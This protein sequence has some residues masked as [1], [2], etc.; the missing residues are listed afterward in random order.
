MRL[1]LMQPYFFP[2]LGYFQLITAVDRFILLDDVQYKDRG[3]INRNR[4][5]KPT[6]GHQYINVPIAKHPS[7][8]RIKDIKT[9]EE[10]TWK[11]KIVRQIAHYEKAAPFFSDVGHLVSDAFAFVEPSV[12]RLNAHYLRSVWAYLGIE[13]KIELSST[14]GLDYSAVHGP[15]DWGW[16]ICDQLGAGE[17]INP[18]GGASLFEKERFEERGI[19]LTFIESTAP[20][21]DQ[22]RESFEPDLSII[23]VLMF[24]SPKTVSKMLH[25]FNLYSRR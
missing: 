16:T 5:L 6:E 15:G 13:F 7:T 9:I 19:K 23:D 17:Y 20:H 12:A 4:I 25:D 18:L 8:T 24:N 2:Y 11:K 21:Y 1:A 3:W 22:H 10:T 14:M